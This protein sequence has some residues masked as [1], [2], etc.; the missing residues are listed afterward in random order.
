MAIID[1]V[2]MDVASDDFI[3]QKFLSDK[4]WELTLG[5]QLVVNE[6]QEAIFVKGGIALDTFT[7][8]TH[9]LVSGNIP[10]LDKII[11]LP[12]GGTTPFTTEVWFINK[13]SEEYALGHA[14][15]YPCD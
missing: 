14:S 6:G 3:V 13:L 15:T 10:L 11:N 7:P 9:T 2:K 5:S 8:G 1:I 4:Q 12:F